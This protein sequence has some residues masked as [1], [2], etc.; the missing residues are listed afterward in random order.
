MRRGGIPEHGA[1]VEGWGED[2]GVQSHKSLPLVDVLLLLNLNFSPGY[3]C[4][5]G[6]SVAPRARGSR[7]APRFDFALRDLGLRRL[8]RWQQLA[9][10]VG[11]VEDFWWV[12]VYPETQVVGPASA[13][14]CPAGLLSFC[15]C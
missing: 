12:L 11:V 5:L 8:F 3:T 4:G 14:Q 13:L 6:F 9:F 7:R 10:L 15:L 1:T 2:S